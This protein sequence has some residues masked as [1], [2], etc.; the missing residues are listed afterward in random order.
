M[1]HS[2]VG[3]ET[4]SFVPTGIA[5]TSLAACVRSHSRR[6]TAER[7]SGMPVKAFFP[8]PVGRF[9]ASN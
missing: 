1:Q 4:A 5:M 3:T 8:T 9:A 7:G 2:S 6:S